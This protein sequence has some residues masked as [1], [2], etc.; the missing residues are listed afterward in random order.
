MNK[1]QKRNLK[2]IIISSSLFALFFSANIFLKYV[3]P[4]RFV[5]GLASII[6]KD[7]LGFIVPFIMYFSIYIYIGGPVLKKCLKNISK[8]HIFD[9]NFLMSF[10]TFGAFFLG[11]YKGINGLEVEGFDEGVSVMIFYQIGEW[12][13]KYATAN[14]RKSIT[15]LMEIRPDSAN[16][17]LDGV[18]SKVDPSTLKKDDIVAIY[19]GEKVPVDGIVIKG[20]S[21][22]DMKDLTGEALPK[23]YK[24]NDNI[25]SGIINIDSTIFVKASTAFSN[26]TVNKI[27]DLVINESMRKS[28]AEKFI[29]K[30]ARYYTPIVVFLS[31][32]ILF[33]FGSITK[34]YMKWTYTALSFLVVSC[35]CA[36]VISIPLSFFSSIGKASKEG[37]MIKGSTFIEMY[38]KANIFVFDKT[39]TLTKGEFEVEKINSKDEERIL[40]YAS[41]CEMSSSHP[42]GKCII[43]KYNSL[44]KKN[45]PNNAITK[46]YPG[47][48]IVSVYNNDKIYC[49][50]DVL[51][52]DN[53]IKFFET[54]EIGSI[55]HVSLNDEYLGFIVVNDKIKDEAKEVID[56]LNKQNYQTIMLSG[57]KEEVCRKATKNLSLSSF[58]SNLLPQD[59]VF[60][61]DKIIINK[62]S[63]D[64]VCFVG[65]GIND[66]PVLMKADVGL[67]MGVAGS[68]AAI[69]ASDVVLMKD[70]L[71][72]II[73]TK[74]LAKK[75]MK[76]VYQNIYFSLIV[77][78]FILVLSFF[79][80]VNMWFA[81][82]GDVGV[83]FIAIVNATR[84]NHK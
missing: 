66:A 67:S 56:F 1:K 58:K 40:Y 70:D 15:S 7:G 16:I 78:V 65:D 59:K 12:F 36:L 73:E 26:S 55:V 29:T 75:T 82:F 41:I 22:F 38:N 80:L 83:C 32:I 25:I 3:F 57:D 37:I 42:I 9:E 71:K 74:N 54:N 68:D 77:K 52:K 62:K 11:I 39:G 50:N 76:I 61:L 79:G 84:I 34:D 47:K 2:K 19:P 17:V 49:G 23:Y 45:I 21:S 10:A 14:S 18:I 27:L 8:G 35:P 33:V 30:F 46:V 24:E 4:D 31:L 51:M 48:G 28:K 43:K 64:V 69:E 5:D 60:E 44:Y 13:E 53:N 6:K 72:G 81:V 63:K 20:E